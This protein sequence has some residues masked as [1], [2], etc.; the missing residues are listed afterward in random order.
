MLQTDTER[1]KGWEVKKKKDSSSRG[2]RKVEDG[3]R[4]MQRG[5]REGRNKDIGGQHDK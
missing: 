4:R 5:T 3:K 1:R 2:K